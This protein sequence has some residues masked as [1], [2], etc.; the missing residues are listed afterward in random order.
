MQIRKGASFLLLAVFIIFLG[1]A[2]FHPFSH[3]TIHHEDGGG[4]ECPICLWLFYAAAISLFIVAFF[5]ILQVIN[6]IIFFQAPQVIKLSI[7]A[8]I[9]RAP[10]SL[11]Y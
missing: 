11:H 1:I 6:Y 8:N 4:H 10:P 7:P 2:I 5:V 9:S 3:E